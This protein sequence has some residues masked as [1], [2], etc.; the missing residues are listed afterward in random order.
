MVPNQYLSIIILIALLSLAGICSATESSESYAY[1]QGGESTIMSSDN[2][3]LLMVHDLNPDLK[4]TKAGNTS[5]IPSNFIQYGSL[6]M[7]AVV[8]FSDSDE[9]IGSLMIIE[10]LSFT[11]DNKTLT[12]QARPLE[13]YDG[14]VLT[15]Y[16]GNTT[17]L[18]I[19]DKKTFNE[20]EINLEIMSIPP[21][22]AIGSNSGC[23]TCRSNCRKDY[24]CLEICNNIVCPSL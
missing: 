2:T 23:D 13:Y 14:T 24:G 18:S 19:L 17:N 8:N 22:N 16:L 15:P 21:E 7:N 6:P 20:T 5:H 1:L 11:D 12:L 9:K 3:M 10:N 4:L